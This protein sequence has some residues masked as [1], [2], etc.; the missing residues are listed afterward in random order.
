MPNPLVVT[1]E[2]KV[3]KAPYGWEH[4]GDLPP[5]PA[6][7]NVTPDW[8]LPQKDN[9]NLLAGSASDDWQAELDYFVD[10]FTIRAGKHDKRSANFRIIARAEDDIAMPLIVTEHPWLRSKAMRNLIVEVF[11]QGFRFGASWE[12]INGGE[13]E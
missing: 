9:G 2:G 5:P 1:S 6:V 13:R 3:A 4:T 11:A 7:I 12:N 10:A 8:D